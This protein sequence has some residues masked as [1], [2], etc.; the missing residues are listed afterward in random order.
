MLSTE[1]FYLILISWFLVIFLHLLF[2]VAAFCKYK[3]HR[4]RK[5]KMFVYCYF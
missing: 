4:L 2:A 3:D 1:N 5:N